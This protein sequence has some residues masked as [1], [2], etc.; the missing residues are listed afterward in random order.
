M[1]TIKLL[2][3]QNIEILNP[4]M[5]NKRYTY[6]GDFTNPT[7]K[8]AYKDLID[9]LSYKYY[10]IFCVVE[11]TVGNVWGLTKSDNDNNVLLQLK[12][13]I[14]KCTFQHYYDWSDYIYF[15]DRRDEWDDG[16]TMPLE[17]YFD[18]IYNVPLEYPPSINDIQCVIPYIEPQWFDDMIINPH[19][20]LECHD[21]YS[22]IVKDIK[23]YKA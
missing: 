8:P 21:G 23:Y 6:N 2:T 20:F 9:K 4:L 7:L 14:G 22:N 18:K 16:T 13:P 19:K 11:G 15:R 5:N 10:P 12:V 3:V 1:K 17:E